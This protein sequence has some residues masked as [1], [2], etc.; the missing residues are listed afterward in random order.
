MQG[1]SNEDSSSHLLE[2]SLLEMSLLDLRARLGALDSSIARHEQALK[3]LERDR[4]NVKLA[5]GAF[6]YPILTLPPEVT[7]EI[8]LRCLPEANVPP[9]GD[10]API[11]LLSVCKEW[12]TIAISV[13]RLWN[14]V[15]LN[16]RHIPRSI[17]LDEHILDVWFTR[18]GSCPLALTLYDSLLPEHDTDDN[19]LLVRKL[20]RRHGSR[21]RKLELYVDLAVLRTFDDMGPFPLL[22]QLSVRFPG[23]P[24][25]ECWEALDSAVFDAAPLLRQLTLLDGTP[26][27]FLPH[28]WGCLTILDVYVDTVDECLEA[29]RLAPLLTDCTFDIPSYSTCH[30]ELVHHSHLQTLYILGRDR[31]IPSRAIFDHLT[32]PSL[33]T[34]QIVG[35]HDL[36][37]DDAFAHFIERS[38]PPLRKFFLH[39]YDGYEFRPRFLRCLSGLTHIEF[40]DVNHTFED[41]FIHL[42]ADEVEDFLPDLQCL[43]FAESVYPGSGY[44]VLAKAVDLRWMSDL[45]GVGGLQSLQVVWPHDI[46]PYFIAML[47]SAESFAKSQL[48]S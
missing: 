35:A 40:N 46:R 8:F 5:L 22:Q 15:Y 41:G 25:A 28:F 31:M 33:H 19:E 36:N 42:L 24:D 47:P 29:L 27:S 1:F 18:A 23:P 30:V 4:A 21:L 10:D 38:S 43:V 44:A 12:R 34:L 20:I 37:E 48:P 11:V 26:L 45:P 13:Q 9:S 16:F 14:T 32:L 6:T 17:L 7:T 39:K 2:E 3:D